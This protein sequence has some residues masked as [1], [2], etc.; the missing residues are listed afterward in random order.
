MPEIRAADQGRRPAVQR[1]GDR[2]KD[3]RVGDGKDG[4]SNRSHDEDG[5][6][7]EP[8]KT[9]SI[10]AHPRRNRSRS[11]SSSRSRS[12]RRRRRLGARERSRDKDRGNSH[13]QRRR[14]SSRGRG[15]TRSRDGK[16]ARR[17]G[18]S[19]IRRRQSRRQRRRRRQRPS[20]DDSSESSSS[21]SSDKRGNCDRKSAFTNVPKTAA[22]PTPAIDKTPLPSQ[23]LLGYPSW[24]RNPGDLAIAKGLE[25]NH[26]L[27]GKTDEEK[28][29]TVEIAKGVPEF[30]TLIDT[31]RNQALQANSMALASGI[32][33]SI[34]ASKHICL[35]YLA[36][37][38]K[39]GSACRQ[40]HPQ[41]REEIVK[42]KAFFAKHPCKWGMQCRMRDRCLYTHPDQAMMAMAQQQA[43]LQVLEQQQFMV[44][45][46]EVGLVRF[47]KR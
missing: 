44:Q 37:A 45:K 34:S 19:C 24:L 21:S 14:S 13:R 17:R 40:T 42:W 32:V 39:F 5:L 33:P 15:R 30:L 43:H 11:R 23:R 10:N 4:R 6:K 7:T 20:G 46:T 18:R 25:E 28:R 47:P 1:E 3:V 9:T 38:C 22:K 8:K 2:P 26:M 41:D 31:Q 29:A 36:G 16:K 27:E 35:S 12:R